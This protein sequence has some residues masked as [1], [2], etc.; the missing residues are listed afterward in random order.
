MRSEIQEIVGLSTLVV[1]PRVE[2]TMDVILLHGY[3]M[4]P[5]DLEPF[6][7]SLGIPARFLL[8]TAPLSAP[9]GGHSWWDIDEPQRLSDLSRGPRDLANFHPPQHWSARQRFLDF[10]RASRAKTQSRVL[11]ICGFS[12]GGMVAC[13]AVLCGQLQVDGLA[14]LS[15]SRVAVDEWRQYQ[16]QLVDLPVLVSHGRNDMDLSFAAGEALRDFHLAGRAEVTWVPF[17]GGHE[18]PLLVWRRLRQFLKALVKR[19]DREGG[20]SVNR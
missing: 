10:C 15:S 19:H 4:R 1:E 20:M 13:D 3:A 14:M 11:A 17:D 8:P 12:Q 7:H 9:M 2:A 6:A 16:R 5:H 18:I